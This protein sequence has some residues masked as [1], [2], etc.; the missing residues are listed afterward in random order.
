[1]LQGL[2][3]RHPPD[4]GRLSPREVP[5]PRDA[6]G[7]LQLWPSGSLPRSSSP[8]FDLVILEAAQENSA[9]VLTGLLALFVG[10][11]N[12]RGPQPLDAAIGTRPRLGVVPPFSV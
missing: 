5:W 10:V 12:K 6:E 2:P 9:D 3:A 8:L 4:R 11:L 1:M 7:N